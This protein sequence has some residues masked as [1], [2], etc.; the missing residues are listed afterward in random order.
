MILLAFAD[1]LQTLV[2]MTTQYQKSC[3]FIFHCDLKD[4]VDMAKL[5]KE[6]ENWL[7]GITYMGVKTHGT[8]GW[9]KLLALQKFPLSLNEYVMLSIA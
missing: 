1:R 6:L 9:E 4:S 7:D 2:V 3:A 5:W 8:S